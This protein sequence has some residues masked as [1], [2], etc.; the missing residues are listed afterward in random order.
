[1]IDGDGDVKLRACGGTADGEG[2]FRRFQLY[3]SSPIEVLALILYQ[4]G[5]CPPPT[6][7]Q[8]GRAEKTAVAGQS[9][10]DAIHDLQLLWGTVTAGSGERRT[11]QS[12]QNTSEDCKRELG[13]KT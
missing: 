9:M 3:Q 7:N 4:S 13:L 5:S 12:F 11:K 10:L 2:G 1:M 8:L 6:Q